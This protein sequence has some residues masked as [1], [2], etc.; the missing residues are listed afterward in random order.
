MYSLGLFVDPEAARKSLKSYS[1]KPAC[2]LVKDQAFYDGGLKP[3]NQQG[4]V[5]FKHPQ[6]YSRIA[7]PAFVHPPIQAAMCACVAGAPAMVACI[8]S[9]TSAL[10]AAIVPFC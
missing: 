7:E 10:S 6:C 3:D 5:T 9:N 2:K 4:L 1:S 8:V